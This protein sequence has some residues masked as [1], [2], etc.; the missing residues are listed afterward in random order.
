MIQ[1]GATCINQRMQ[2]WG[3][4]GVVYSAGLRAPPYGCI[5]G[6]G[7]AGVSPGHK[8]VGRAFQEFILLCVLVGRSRIVL[9]FLS[10]IVHDLT[11]FSSL[12]AELLWRQLLWTLFRPV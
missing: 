11:W 9:A 10:V 8:P 1:P 2:L 4:V 7:A 12:P 5:S 6:K 3:T